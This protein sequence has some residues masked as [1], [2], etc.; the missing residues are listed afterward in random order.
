MA[1]MYS[2][3]DLIF[4]KVKKLYEKEVLGPSLKH[5]NETKKLADN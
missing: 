2:P 5:L 4:D 1:D 3:R